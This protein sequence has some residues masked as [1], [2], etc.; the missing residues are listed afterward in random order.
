MPLSV[1]P[2]GLLP[3]RLVSAAV[4]VWP[5][6]SLRATSSSEPSRALAASEEFIRWSLRDRLGASCF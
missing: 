4:L 1:W 2:W 3:E 5:D 6:A